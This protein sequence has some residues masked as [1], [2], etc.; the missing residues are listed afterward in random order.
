MSRPE[1]LQGATGDE[2]IGI[3]RAWRALETWTFARK[4]GVVRELIRRYPANERYEFDHACGPPQEW[5]PRLHH[6][7]AAALGISIVAAGKLADLA[8]TL[9]ARLPGIGQAL[10]G[11]RL[12]PARVKMIVDETSVLDREDMFAKA[13]QIILAGLDQC[14]TWTDLLRLVQR[15]V[16]T[17]DPEGAEKRRLQ[18]EREGAR[19]RFWRENTGTCGLQGTGLP[20]D[21]ALAAHAN[22]E[23]R[24]LEYKAVPVREKMDILR[25]MAYL[26]ILNSVTVAQRVAWA[27]V[28]EEARKAGAEKLAA[29]TERRRAAQQAKAKAR[30][31]GQ[32][33]SEGEDGQGEDGPYGGPSGGPDDRGPDGGPTSG[34]E[35]G[36]PDGGPTGGPEGSGPEGSGPE[37]S[38]PADGRPDGSDPADGNP[39]DGDPDC[40]GN[41]GLMDGGPVAGPGSDIG[42]QNG[43]SEQTGSG[44][45]GRGAC[46][47]CGGA[48]GVAGLP[49][50]ASL[51]VPAAAL[52]F[53]AE[54]AAE[55]R[56]PTGGN[57]E[58]SGAGGGGPGRAASGSVSVADTPVGRDLAGRPGLVGRSA[59]ACPACGHAGRRKRQP[60]AP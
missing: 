56:G 47:E 55:A 37:G 35:D 5:D 38:G 12:D 59:G 32:D 60:A 22:I 10:E 7:V 17:V 41:G 36:G 50:R 53:L 46:P 3:G 8:W 9:D 57:Q 34:P 44:E 11:N 16:I 49:L 33:D 45:Q 13:E 39:D 51:T 29:K 4:L 24:A 28:D 15:A 20:T 43:S 23:A 6:E 42:G 27:R 40:G 48:G 30:R 25:V 52:E 2:V 54:L 19:I 18:A 14:R 1:V 26:D 31:D 58:G 21:Q